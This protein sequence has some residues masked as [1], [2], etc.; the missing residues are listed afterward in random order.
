MSTFP[1]EALGLGALQGVTEFLPVSS[2][3]H[4]A[5]ASLFTSLKGGSLTLNVMLHA[6]TLLAT[7]YV[8]HPSLQRLFKDSAVAFSEPRQLLSAPGTQ[9]IRV[10]ILTS[11][12]TACI[13]LLLRHRVETW[14][15]SPL[16][17]GIGF[18]ITA[19]LLLASR[20]HPKRDRMTPTVAGSILLGIGQGLAVLPGISRSGA[21]ITVAL[22]LGLKPRR[23][24]EISMLMS[25]P[26]VLGAV[27]LELPSASLSAEQWWAGVV[28]ATTACAIGVLALSWLRSLVTQGRFFWFFLWVLPAGL[29]TLTLGT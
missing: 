14:T 19:G 6:G 10:V 22:W 29:L 13:G 20:F 15:N 11:I 17:I 28:G 25:L 24:F 5:I 9:D 12:P 18:L 3:G 7:A 16:A 8:L 4:V 1:Y 27:L 21:T 2:S 26:A 23:A